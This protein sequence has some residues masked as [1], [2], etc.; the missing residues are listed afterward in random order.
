VGNDAPRKVSEEVKRVEERL[1]VVEERLAQT[2]KHL[3]EALKAF[4]ELQATTS[5]PKDP[6]TAPR[7]QMLP[8]GRNVVVLDTQL[9]TVK[10]VEGKE[11]RYQV[12]TLGNRV[13]IIDVEQGRFTDEREAKK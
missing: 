5:K 12:V 10:T 11:S 1:A 3:V 8:A 4:K 6:P 9:G 13:F 7:Y 2:E